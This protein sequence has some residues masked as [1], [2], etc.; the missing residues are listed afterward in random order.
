MKQIGIFLLLASV[1]SSLSRRPGQQAQ[2]T[3]Q[4]PAYLRRD[5]P[6]TRQINPGAQLFP[7]I[8]VSIIGQDHMRAGKPK[9]AV[10]VLKLNLLA[11]P[12]SADAHET[13]AEAYLKDGQNDLARQHAEKALALLDSHAVPASSWSDTEPYRCEIRRGAQNVTQEAKCDR[14][15]HA[16]CDEFGARAGNRVPR[17]PELPRDGG[18]SCGQLHHGFV[19]VGEILAFV[20]LI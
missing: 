5:K 19:G 20:N 8:T 11:C 9:L 15:D 18:G 7:E 12:E 13:L 16:R 14:G 4:P 3:V 6:S 17:L 1:I 10:E 2:K